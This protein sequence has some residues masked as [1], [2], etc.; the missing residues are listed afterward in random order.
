MPFHRRVNDWIHEHTSWKTFTHTCG[1]VIAL[2]PD[3]I[4]AGFD[5][6]NPVQCSAAGMHPRDLKRQF[7]DR[8]TFWG[9]GID[10]QHTLP[11]GTPDQVRQQVRERIAVFG[12]DGGF[13]F[14]TIHNIQ[15][16][17]PVENLLALFETVRECG[18]Y[19]L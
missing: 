15:A 18:S 12:P 6:M 3:F 13:V 2:I 17:V 5:I 19:P 10:T 4:E 9:G 7:G 11:F 14:N 16:R 1:S 8:I